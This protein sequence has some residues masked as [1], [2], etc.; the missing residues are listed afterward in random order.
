[1]PWRP[2]LG[3]FLP[4]HELKATLQIEKPST[5]RSPQCDAQAMHDFHLIV[6]M[7]CSAHV[8]PSVLLWGL[9]GNGG[10]GP[11]GSCAVLSQD[12]LH[13]RCWQRPAPAVIATEMLHSQC[14]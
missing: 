13:T 6:K 2:G 3:I 5:S 7:D 12:Q 9:G 10:A 4:S 11:R 8:P 1:M 14:W